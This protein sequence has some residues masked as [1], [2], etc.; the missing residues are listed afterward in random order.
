MTCKYWTKRPITVTRLPADFQDPIWGGFGEDSGRVFYQ[1][2]GGFYQI[3]G[4]FYQ[5]RGGF[6][7][8]LVNTSNL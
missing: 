7:H 6:T 1:I 3:R 8:L 5:I 4:G 2:W